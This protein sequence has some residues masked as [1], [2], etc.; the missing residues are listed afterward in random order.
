VGAEARY[1]T[2]GAGTVQEGAKARPGFGTALPGVRV[3]AQTTTV[4]RAALCCS[5]VISGAWC[6][7]SRPGADQR[8][9][10]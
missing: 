6:A 9:I 4:W 7:T 5:S 8:V 2:S 10:A 1:G 3:A